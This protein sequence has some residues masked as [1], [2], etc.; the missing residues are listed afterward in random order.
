[1]PRVVDALFRQ[2]GEECRPALSLTAFV[3]SRRP[4]IWVAN[5][6]LSTR[7]NSKGGV[8]QAEAGTGSANSAESFFSLLKRAITGAWNHISREHLPRYANEFAFRWNTR[9]TTDGQRLKRF[10]EGIASKRLTYR[11]VPHTFMRLLR[12]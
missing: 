1:M 9:H 10:T 11:Q 5:K 3:I 8:T 2:S 6:A 4:R 12:I 7:P